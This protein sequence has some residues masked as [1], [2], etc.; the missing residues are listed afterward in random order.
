MN[1][2]DLSGDTVVSR[3]RVTEDPDRADP[4]S[5]T[6]LLSYDQPYANHNGGGMAFGP[7]GY[8]YIGSGDGGSGGDPEGRAQNRDT[9]LGKLLRI[10]VDGG[11]P[12]ALPP[13]N[14]F[15]SGGGRPEIWS[16]G[17]RN[18]WRFAFDPATGDLYVG[19]VGQGDWEEIDFQAAG[20]PG[21]MNFGWDF[22]EGS[23]DYEDR[24]PEGLIDPIA[25]YSHVEGGCSITAGRVVRA[26]AL[27]SWQGVFL[28][29]DYCT[30]YIWG[31]L[32]DTGGR[33]RS[34]R[35]FETG[36]QITSFGTGPAGEIYLLDRGGGL[37]RLSPVS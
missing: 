13:D 26:P 19:D 18:P 20:S 33:W 25:E 1:Y 36:L 9:L 2:T 32:R 8:L 35:L 11:S 15:A 7:D 5:E 24:A 27:P 30:G 4:S 29:G 31:V 10:D 28:Y 23:H 16:Y 6:V 3:F 12:Y 37:Y 22:R 17:L 21:G 14:P 34:A